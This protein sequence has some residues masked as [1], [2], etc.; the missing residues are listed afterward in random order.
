M[1]RH[2]AFGFRGW[3]DIGHL[4]FLIGFALITWRMAIKSMEKKLI[5]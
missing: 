1:V 3:V 5:L 4:A 2:A